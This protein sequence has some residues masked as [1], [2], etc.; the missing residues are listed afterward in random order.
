MKKITRKG[1]FSKQSLAI[2]FFQILALKNLTET[3]DGR[4]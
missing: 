1:Y 4:V 3:Q 2:T